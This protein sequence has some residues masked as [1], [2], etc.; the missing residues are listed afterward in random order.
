MIHS[1]H[2]IVH[3]CIAYYG[4]I[5]GQVSL[6]SS[7]QSSRQGL[8]CWKGLELLLREGLGWALLGG[9]C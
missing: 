9:V 1:I 8:E 7:A 6:L 2:D 5:R 4:P 3:D